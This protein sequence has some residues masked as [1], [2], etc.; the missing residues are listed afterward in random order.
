MK[1]LFR[2]IPKKILA[3][4][5][6]GCIIYSVFSSTFSVL[7][8]K[9]VAAKLED[10]FLAY[11]LGIFLFILLWNVFEFIGDLNEVKLEKNIEC[12]VFRYYI[13]KLYD[14]RPNILKD[15]NTGYIS[16]LIQKLISHQLST[17]G[18]F[19]HGLFLD[20]TYILYCSFVLARKNIIFGILL[21]GIYA[22]C[23]LSRFL[24]TEL[25][26][27]KYAAELAVEEGN[28]NRDYID[29][30]MNINTI[31]KMGAISYFDNRFDKTR[32]KVFTATKKWMFW[33]ELG[34]MACKSLAFMFTPIS[35][36]TVYL[37]SRKGI[38]FDITDIAFL[39]SVFIQVPHNVRNLAKGI[40]SYNQFNVTLDKL[41]L[42]VN[43]NN[44]RRE[45][46]EGIFQNASLDNVSYS[47]KKGKQNMQ[48]VIPSFQAKKGDIICI[49]GE[50]GQG[51]TTLLHLLSQEIEND[52]TTIEGYLNVNGQ[53][54][55]VKD[56]NHRL[57][58]VF[59]AQDT[60]MFDMT[61]RDNLTLGKDIP[62]EI[63][64]SYL[65]EVG[66]GE[67]LK[68][69]PEGLDTSIGERGVH[70]ST[71]Q[72]QRLNLIRGL[73]IQ[74]KEIYLLDEPTSNVDGKTEEKIIEMIRR[75]LKDKTVI[76]VTH[77]EAIMKICN[78]SYLFKNGILKEENR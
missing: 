66:M 8:T 3:Q 2:G 11:L 43:N 69:Q 33:N 68:Q 37:L 28:Q 53:K 65:N 31:Q 26:T 18:S 72:R 24:I 30:A 58:C 49:H 55:L 48:I 5:I 45:K 10:T 4:S 42:I 16:G 57:D 13:D 54:T 1:N 29:A 44:K 75:T 59:I 27:K 52:N 6:F 23:N 9:L 34:F 71:G 47:Y 67:W 21:I 25:V 15:N 77:R 38:T 14:I 19:I 17:Y 64:I 61:L 46:F 56:K 51:K 50:S 40:S 12:N 74:D 63:L 62:D 60:E 39:T 22:L 73:L 35:L 20:V 78:R 36:L 70:V 32:K 7:I 76:I 41:N